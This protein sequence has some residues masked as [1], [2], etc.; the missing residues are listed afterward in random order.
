[1]SNRKIPELLSPCGSFEK[2]E[3]AIRYG[4]DAAALMFHF[5]VIQ[6]ILHVAH[7]TSPLVS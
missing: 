2:L 7:I 6:R 4:A 5:L 1:M 3:A